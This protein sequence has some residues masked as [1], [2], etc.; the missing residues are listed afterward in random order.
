LPSD[1]CVAAQV[2]NLRPVLTNAS[3]KKNSISMTQEN[4]SN[5]GDALTSELLRV[6]QYAV[7]VTDQDARVVAWSPKAAGYFSLPESA[8]AGN[9]LVAACAGDLANMLHTA[10]FPLQK[11]PAPE[12]ESV[13]G[14]HEFTNSEVVVSAKII[15]VSVEEKSLIL[16]II[17]PT[18]TGSAQATIDQA[19]I[20]LLLELEVFRCS[21]Q[22]VRGMIHD[23]N[24]TLASTLGYIFLSNEK[25]KKGELQKLPEFLAMA[26]TA[27]E[28]TRDLIAL[29][30]KLNRGDEDAQAQNDLSSAVREAM[31]M[32]GHAVPV[33]I[34]VTIDIQDNLPTRMIGQSKVNKLIMSLVQNVVEAI[35]DRGEL[36]VTL[37]A[38]TGS[39]ESC[40]SCGAILSGN[41]CVLSIEDSGDGIPAN[42]ASRIYEPAFTTKQR[43]TGMGLY[44][45][46]KLLHSCQ[47]HL[48][49]Q[50]DVRKGTKLNMYFEV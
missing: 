16:I 6:T 12:P 45:V 34:S 33:N 37:Y 47:A 11:T 36:R 42:I 40:V 22:L 9:F 4:N 30:Q 26:Q 10:I 7:I 3:N 31:E 28:N 15:S 18:E 32:A 19:H 39:H 2:N 41:Y 35:S 43:G 13:D 29:V 14:M 46:N 25:L 27:G 21:R 17:A 1:L 50:Q 38:Q 5:F 23:V 44:L 48:R 8:V 20:D 24:N 49:L